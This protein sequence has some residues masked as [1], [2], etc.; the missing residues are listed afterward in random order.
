MQASGEHNSSVSQY[1]RDACCRVSPNSIQLL[2]KIYKLK[3]TPKAIK[4]QVNCAKA[5]LIKN[6]KASGKEI[7]PK[8]N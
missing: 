5:Y 8:Y 4:R 6:R 2:P 7:L 1:N 3:E